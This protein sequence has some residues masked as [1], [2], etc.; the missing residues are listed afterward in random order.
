MLADFEVDHDPVGRQSLRAELA[1]QDRLAHPAK[2]GDDH[3]LLRPSQLQAPE[4]QVEQ[5]QLVVA[6]HDGLGPGSGVGGVG[7][8]DGVHGL[9]LSTLVIF[10]CFG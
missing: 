7:V 10:M 1:Q 8:Q 2:A 6:A 9:T 4:Q 3:G 5:S